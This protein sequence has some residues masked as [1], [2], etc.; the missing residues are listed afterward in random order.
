MIDEPATK[1]TLDINPE[2]V[3]QIIILAKGFHAKEEVVIPEEPLSQSEDWARQVLADHADDP[4]YQE[5][6][7]MIEDLEPDQQ[8]CLVALMWVGRGDFT[9]SEWPTALGA[10]SARR[11]NHTADYLIASPLVASYLEEGLNQLGYECE[12]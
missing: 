2:I 11:S 1:A 9:A 4:T 6:K 7:G 8:E 3:C 12:Y 10:A 5:L